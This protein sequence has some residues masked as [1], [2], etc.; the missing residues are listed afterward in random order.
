MQQQL[1]RLGAQHLQ[2]VLLIVVR[3]RLSVA[4]ARQHGLQHDLVIL[5]VE[6]LMTPFAIP[7]T[8]QNS[9]SSPIHACCTLL[10]GNATMLYAA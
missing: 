7:A 5:I 1:L 9:I 2:F 8:T 6:T 4:T 3:F 10:N